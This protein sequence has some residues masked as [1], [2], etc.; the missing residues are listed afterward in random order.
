MKMN[1]AY[2]RQARYRPQKYKEGLLGYTRPC[3]LEDWANEVIA[4]EVLG[5]GNLGEF[6]EAGLAALLC[7]EVGR[8]GHAG[9]VRERS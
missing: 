5:G 6:G 9:E 2:T 4:L 3:P 8:V 1:M 7:G